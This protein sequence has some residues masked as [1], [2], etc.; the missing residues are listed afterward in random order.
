MLFN[1]DSSEYGKEVSHE[2]PIK[3]LLNKS[4]HKNTTG[5]SGTSAAN[6]VHKFVVYTGVNPFV[7]D[8]KVKIEVLTPYEEEP[9][10]TPKLDCA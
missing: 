3:E 1:T 8:N 2:F 9:T 7:L 10:P 5:E 6:E 4:K